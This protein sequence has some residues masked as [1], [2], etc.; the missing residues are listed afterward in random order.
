MK[1]ITLS[2]SVKNTFSKT[3]SAEWTKY[4][5]DNYEEVKNKVASRIHAKT[6]LP[7]AVSEDIAV[8]STLYGLAG[9]IA[10]KTECPSAAD[11]FFALSMWKANLLATDELRE[12]AKA[13]E[14]L[15]LD[16]PFVSEDGEE[17]SQNPIVANASVDGWKHGLFLARWN[18]LLGET[19]H[20][21]HEFLTK[22]F[23][24]RT[25]A[26]FWART[27]NCLPMH[28]TCKLFHTNENCVSVLCHRVM[29]AWKESGKEYYRNVA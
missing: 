7:Y 11:E 28:E 20:A 21:L 6:R 22:N 14:N 18:E 9:L 23:S 27:M 8:Y 19:G 17:S 24:T 2:S 25:S 1:T 13:R 4:V 26:I 3:L 16:N 10:G 29:K 12:R 15:L 5:S